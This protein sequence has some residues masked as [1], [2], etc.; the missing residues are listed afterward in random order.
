MKEGAGILRAKAG[1]LGLVVAFVVLVATS[2][3]VFAEGKVLLSQ[4]DFTGFTT[5]VSVEGQGGWGIGMIPPPSVTVDE[6]VTLYGDGN[7][8]W[9]FSNAVG[10]GSMNDMPFA[11][12][13][14]GIPN[15]PADT[16]TNPVLGRPELFAGESSTTARYKRFIA[17]FDFRS[18]T[19]APQEDLAVSV[20][21]DNGAGGRMGYVQLVDSGTGIDVVTYDI[22][23]AGGFVGP[24][25]IAAGLS[26]TAWHNVVLDVY[27][28]DGPGNDVVKIYLNGELIHL[29]TTWED[30]FRAADPTSYPLGVPVQTLVFSSGQS[31]VPGNS[32]KGYYFD[33]VVIQLSPRTLLSL[34]EVPTLSQWWQLLFVL[35]LMGVAVYSL[36]TRRTKG[37]WNRS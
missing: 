24:I 11:P 9:R 22:D 33:N 25:T 13:N 18:A 31:G 23:A 15:Y 28:Y 36:R 14:A 26:Y 7:Y 29:G 16:S 4:T 34:Q 35:S 20:S 12:R 21:P 10:S 8:V 19:G 6:E 30:Y 17:S 1:L 32:G 2:P 37:R 27:F 5:G 3:P